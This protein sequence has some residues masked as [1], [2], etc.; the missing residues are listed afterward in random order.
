MST[1]YGQYAAYGLGA[2]TADH[3]A[4]RANCLN[5]TNPEIMWPLPG[6]DLQT[7]LAIKQ[8][9]GC[10]V[11]VE[12]LLDGIDDDEFDSVRGGLTGKQRKAAARSHGRD[13]GAYPEPDPPLRWCQRC[14]GGFVVEVRNP[15][16]RLCP[17]CAFE[18]DVDALRKE[19]KR[20]HRAHRAVSA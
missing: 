10:P 5:M 7:V 11:R 9:E 3:W 18:R 8:C 2:D 4:N 12:C 19:K 1:V 17:S 6:A 14:S 16:A 15:H 20:A 13:V